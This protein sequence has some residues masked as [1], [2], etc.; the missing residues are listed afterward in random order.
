VGA[1]PAQSP[2]E[3][4]RPPLTGVPSRYVAPGDGQAATVRLPRADAH[5]DPQGYWEQI[6]LEVAAWI[7]ATAQTVAAELYEGAYAPFSAR[8]TLERQAAYYAEFL[9]FAGGMPNPRAWEQL[10]QTAG[11]DGLVDAVRGAARWRKDNGLP[12]TLPP[13]VEPGV[14]PG[15]RAAGVAGDPVV[16]AAPA[17]PPVVAPPGP[18]GLAREGAPAPVPPGGLPGPGPQVYTPSPMPPPPPPGTPPV[19]V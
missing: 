11:A 6:A 13:P 14:P 16:P 12:V 2:K 5:V 17:A 15:E 8:V 3:I 1:S 19:G 7:D 9:F 10:Y 18:P 4:P